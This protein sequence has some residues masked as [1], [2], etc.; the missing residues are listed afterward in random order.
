MSSSHEYRCELVRQLE[1]V[2]RDLQNMVVG[3]LLAELE[4]QVGSDKALDLLDAAE[5]MAARHKATSN[6]YHG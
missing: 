4:M 2:P 1:A 3:S 5:T 6:T